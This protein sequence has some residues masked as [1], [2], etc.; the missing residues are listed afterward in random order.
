MA[1]EALLDDASFRRWVALGLDAL[2]T[3]REEID[4][5]NVYPVPDGDTGTNMFLT[6]EHAAAALEGVESGDLAATSRALARGALLGARGNS[7]V[8]L[9]QL[10]RGMS[11]EIAEDPG[12]GTEGAD[13]ATVT[14]AFAR[15]SLLADA[16][17]E[18]PVEGTIL[19]VA[20]AAA[21]GS[22]GA[23]PH[24]L[25]EVV[26][27]ATNAARAALERTPEQLEALRRA[28]VVDAGGRGLVVLLDA[29]T[30]TLT[31]KRPPHT[32]IR[33]EPEPCEGPIDEN[34]YDGPAFEVMFMLES[35]DNAVQHLRSVLSE[36]GDSLV[37]V[38]GDPLW[39]VHVH[40]DDAGAAVEAA[41]AAGRP[42]SIRITHLLR[43]DALRASGR[44]GVVQP[45][46]LV[47]VAHGEGIRAVLEE[48]GAT[49]VMA[50]PRQRP[51][52][53]ELLDG[54]HRSGAHEVVL[55]PSDKDTLQVAEA[56]AAEARDEGQRVSVIPSRSVVQ[57][58]AAVAVH[59]PGRPFPDDVV[60]MT[61]AA[62]ATRYGAVTI[63]AREGMTS[64]GICRV[65][66][67]LGLAHGDIVEIGHDVA[68][69]AAAVIDGLCTGGSE[70]VTLVTG[71]ECTTDEL[72]AVKAHLRSTHPALDVV[73]YAGEQPYWPLIVGV[74]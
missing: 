3:S 37:V 64:A 43:A 2:G 36:L 10:L 56:A 25:P 61:R 51:S 54:I 68:G 1:S 16:A 72:A 63:A 58:L 11:A 24:N 5:L 38:G 40:V 55:L 41:I 9:S 29:M 42:S 57:S 46:A 69:V 19:T 50:R 27:S 17:V 52:T 14:R 18:R 39:N 4:S 31:G 45:R 6:F 21:E 12:A 26:I 48:G 35:D 8:I 33:V 71:G 53:A 59:D 22:R 44:G 60:A 70:L 34:G 23:D 49:V 74:E 13:G 32:V 66:D 28:G 62:G 67:V 20:R 65:G 7:G 47:V 15:A 73:V 30:Q